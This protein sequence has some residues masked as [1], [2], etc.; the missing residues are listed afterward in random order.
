MAWWA[1]SVLPGVTRLPTQRPSANGSSPQIFSSSLRITS[2]AHSS[3]VALWNCCRV[4]RRSVYLIITA[5]PRVA[6][7]SPR[8]FF[9]RRIAMAKAATPRY[10]SVLPPPVGNHSKSANAS[11]GFVRSEWF[12][13][14]KEG[15]DKSRNAS[16]NGR[17]DRFLGISKLAISTSSFLRRLSA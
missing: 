6:S 7:K 11:T 17:H 9:R 16:W 15:M 4:K 14:A 5:R 8:L 13:S 2:I 1:S 3:V 10:A 12:G